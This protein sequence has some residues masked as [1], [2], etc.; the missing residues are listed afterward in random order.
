MNA[1]SRYIAVCWGRP[2]DGFVDVPLVRKSS[3]KVVVAENMGAVDGA[4]SARTSFTVACSGHG[5]SVLEVSLYPTEHLL[6][7]AP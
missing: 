7:L 5:A 2:R 6:E 1:T 3:G 4:Q